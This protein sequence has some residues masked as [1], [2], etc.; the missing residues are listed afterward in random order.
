MDSKEV[1]LNLPS[2]DDE[3]QQMR[4]HVWQYFTVHAG[5]RM[6]MLNLF[7]LLTGLIAAG[8]GA[9]V[10]G[11]GTLRLLGG[12][13]GLFL[14]LTAFLF[15]KLDARTAFL[16]KHAEEAM[17]RLEARFPTAKL[18]AVHVG[19]SE[20]RC[21][22]HACKALARVWTYGMSLRLL[23]FITGFCR[24]LCGRLVGL[25]IFRDASLS[26]PSATSLDRKARGTRKLGKVDVVVI[27]PLLEEFLAVRKHIAFE[28]VE[29]EACPPLVPTL[30]EA[31]LGKLHLVACILHEMANEYSALVTERCITHLDPS[32]VV[33]IGIAGGLHK[34]VALGDVIFSL[35][36][37]NF[38][39]ES[40]IVAKEGGGNLLQPSATGT[41]PSATRCSTMRRISRVPTARHSEI[42]SWRASASER[43]WACPRGARAEADQ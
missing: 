23:F 2:E 37:K 17:V 38:M 7:M 40:K 42:G 36:V 1:D 26:Q 11:Q 15:W 27:V 13:L 8:L 30:Y 16:V 33:G 14:A 4:T 22:R 18:R 19:R 25:P 6:S 10:Q 3:H 28:P 21:Q 35:G 41:F 43:L 29:E 12:I 34:D 24:S 32:L 39:F 20:D 31:K 9:C 5:Q